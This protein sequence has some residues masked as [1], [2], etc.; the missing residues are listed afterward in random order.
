VRDPDHPGRYNLAVECDG[1]TYHHALWARE[2]DRL[3]QEVLEGLAWRFYR[4]WSTDW[5]RRRQ[6]EI[7]RLK[8]ALCE[9][10]QLRHLSSRPEISPEISLA[11]AGT[12]IRID[13]PTAAVH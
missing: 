3:R 5:F 12:A 2:R 7:E 11:S 6:A 10:K 13:A 8:M 4:I 9:A 1:A